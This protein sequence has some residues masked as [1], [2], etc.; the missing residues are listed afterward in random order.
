[1]SGSFSALQWIGCILVWLVAWGAVELIVAKMPERGALARAWA[2]V[3]PVL[4]G[5]T[6]L[7][8][9][10]MLVRGLR[11]SPVILP[12]PSAIAGRLAG[13]LPTL[14]ADFVQTFKG[15]L[16][17]YVVGCGAG[18]LVAL[19]STASRSYNAVFCHSAPWFRP[20]PSWAS[21]RSWSCGSASTGNRR[22]RWW[23]S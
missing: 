21:L 5:A 1:M 20:C 10:E 4:F 13:S 17:G 18:A 2:L 22:P 16:A 11:V 23:S 9:W 14:G 12:P 6:L 3:I 15:V 7:F 8:I 19:L